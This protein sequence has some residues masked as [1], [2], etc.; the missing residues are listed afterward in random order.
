[1]ILAI[2][3]WAL[4]YGFELATSTLG[5]M[6]FWIRLEYLGISTLPAF[7]II[8]VI[9]F[10]GK[11][12]W[13]NRKRLIALFFIPALTIIFVWTN[14]LHHLHYADV[15]VD[16]S[17]GIP[18]L[19]I[20]TGIW[21]W[22][23]TVYFYFLLAYGLYL[24][25]ARFKY[26]DSVYRQQNITIIFGAFLPW[27]VNLLYLFGVRPFGHIDLTPYAFTITAFSI[28]FGILRFKLFDLIPVARDKVI[29][30]MQDGVLVL[31]NKDRVI[32]LNEKMRYFLED[33]TT[34]II[35]MKVEYI[36]PTNKKLLAGILSKIN[37]GIE[38]K[39]IIDDNIKY[40]DVFL[41]PLYEKNEVYNGQLLLF[42][43]VT[44][45]KLYG[46][47]LQTQTEELAALNKLKDKLFSIIAHD[48]QG[49]IGSLKELL[50]MTET[51]E[52]SENEIKMVIP[53]ISKYVNNIFELME[54]LLQWSRSQI[55]GEKV[56]R[57]AI[58]M[59]QIVN[60][61][62]VFFEKKAT[63]KGIKLV[64]NIDDK[65]LVYADKNMIEFITRNLV[66]NAIKFC[67]DGDIISINAQVED[68]ITTISVTDTGKGIEEKNLSKLFG[69]ENFTT[70]GTKMEK[71]TGL[72]LLLC[73]E[74]IEKNKGRIWVES[75]LGKGSKFSF[76]LPNVMARV[77]AKTN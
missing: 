18:L 59:K 70:R 48:L 1:M 51:G 56:I 28:A 34:D 27:I 73:K 11:N 22:V 49:P 62:V 30:V 8:F 12:Y 25:L 26:E 37:V 10:I 58:D 13:L 2:S 60:N 75:E 41:T 71:G 4:T 24:L 74:F 47:K 46:E 77:V 16:K 45:N 65:T 31:D 5:D 52:V 54:N 7:W 57:E 17:G 32:Y 33:Y 50:S 42:R 29:E 44:T 20:K 39:T 66:A 9:K 14:P 15:S 69:L 76:T 67:D 63:D 23:N 19:D 40:M 36:F 3:F 72:G 43:D 6:L 68:D 55:S 21:Y 38:Y 35:G 53:H 61:K 64:N